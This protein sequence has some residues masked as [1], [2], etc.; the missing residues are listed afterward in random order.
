MSYEFD[1]NIENYTLNELEN[2]LNISKN[3]DINI[4]NERCSRMNSSIRESKSHDEKYKKSL[5]KFLDEV[6]FKL[7]ANIKAISQEYNGFIE[8]YDKPIINNKITSAN[9]SNPIE[10]NDNVG[11]IINPMS[12]H[13]SLQ[14][15]QI[16]SESTNPYGGNKFVTNYVFNTQFRDNFFSTNPEDCTFTLP[17][18][19]KNVIS[20][21][22]SAVQIPNVFFAYS[23]YKGT[24]QLYI[25]EET[26]NLEAIVSIPSGNYDITSFPLILEKAI[27]IQVIGTWP[28]RFTVSID[29]STYFT[30]IK[31]STYNFRMNILKKNINYIGDC[32]YSKYYIDSNPDNEENKINSCSI[33]TYPEASKF[34]YTMGYLMGYREVEYTGKK[35]YTSESM[36]NIVGNTDY[37]YFCMNEFITGSQYMQNF[38]ILPNG[39]IDENILAIIPITSPKFI[40]TF[41]TNSDYIYKTRNYIGPVDIQKISIK[42]LGPTGALLNIYSNDYV[43]NLQVTSIYDIKKPYD[44]NY[45]ICG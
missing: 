41:A 8:D 11:K 20:I 45:S 18:K 30:T 37:V 32:T 2:F 4:I 43:F 22:L 33:K 39:L 1:F 38:G 26:T 15:I 3:Y 40:S 19:L 29:S 5:A 28:N 27:N 17:I 10:K 6:K 42:L 31:N 24:N 14:K 25:F 9:F 23:D 44:P 13:Q 34:C 7:V 36:F 16:P 21:S 35:T 12:T